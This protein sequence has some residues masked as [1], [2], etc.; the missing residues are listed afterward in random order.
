[1]ISAI[2]SQFYF[3]GNDHE[4]KK[5]HCG[6]FGVT[7][8]NIQKKYSEYRSINPL[9]K[10]D[11]TIFIAKML[12]ESYYNNFHPLLF[13]NSHGNL[14]KELIFDNFR[15]KYDT[16]TSHLNQFPQIKCSIILEA[17]FSGNFPL[18]CEGLVTS[19]DQTHAS[20]GQ[21]LLKALNETLENDVFDL[22]DVYN[23][24]YD[25]EDIPF[26]QKSQTTKM[27][28]VWDREDI[29]NDEAQKVGLKLEQ[30]G[31]CEPAQKG[32]TSLKI[33]PCIPQK[34]FIE[35]IDYLKTHNIVKVNS[36]E[37]KLTHINNTFK[38]NNKDYNDLQIKSAF[39]LWEF[40][41]KYD[42]KSYWNSVNKM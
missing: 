19:S 3:I 21:L 26:E 12:K 10:K 30:I 28:T 42:N 35:V 4:L 37:E 25:N 9:D 13:I 27:W 5:E 17:C 22:N 36:V 15:I 14:N 29:I 24:G 32:N 11:I 31:Q 2:P 18:C 20:Q 38:S 39:N 40:N 34:E 1:M 7:S 33:T 41:Q 8:T 16:I 6:L 23:N